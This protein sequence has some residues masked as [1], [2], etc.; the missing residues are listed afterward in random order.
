MGGGAV[1]F[2]GDVA[3]ALVIRQDIRLTCNHTIDQE[4]EVIPCMA[5][6]F[7]CLIDVKLSTGYM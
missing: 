5:Y 7:P 4:S 3:D 6:V 2:H 1:A